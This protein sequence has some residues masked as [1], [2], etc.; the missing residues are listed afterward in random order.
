[1][2]RYMY[3]L[4]LRN[5]AWVTTGLTLW[6]GIAASDPVPSVKAREGDEGRA[7]YIEHGC[8]QC[9]GYDGQGGFAGSRIAPDPLP[10]TAFAALVRYPANVMPAY[11]PEVLSDRELKQIHD[12]VSA[13]PKPAS[14]EQVRALID[15]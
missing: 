3:R 8:Y 9:H 11:A 13:I 4:G 1:M 15:D 7:A 6:C 12:Y 14:A 2:Q 10:Y 5:L